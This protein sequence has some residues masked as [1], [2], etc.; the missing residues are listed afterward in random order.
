MADQRIE[1]VHRDDVVSALCASVDAERARGRTFHVAGGTTWRM[2]GRA[3]VKDYYDL[4]GVPLEEACFQ[5]TPGWCDWYDT[6]DSQA[7]L[8]YQNTTYPRHLARLK[9]EIDRMMED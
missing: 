2:T 4:L 8:H 5:E 7:I 3:Y 1:F 9:L 6:D